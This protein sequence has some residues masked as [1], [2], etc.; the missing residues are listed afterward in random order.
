MYPVEQFIST[1]PDK[2]KSNLNNISKMS[3]K[4]AYYIEK[5]LTQSEK[6][7][8]GNSFCYLEAVEG[9]GVILLGLILE[10]FGFENFKS[11]ETGIID[12]K[13][14]RLVPSFSKKKRYALL[15]GK[16]QNMRNIINVFNHPDN[17]DGEYIQIIIASEVARDGINLHNVLRGYVLSP[18]WHESGMYQA[19][20]R[21]VR[22]TSHQDLKNRYLLEKENPNLNHKINVD[23]YRLAAVKPGENITKDKTFSFDLR[24]Y[25]EAEK[26]DIDNRKILRYM[27]QCAFDA[28]LN[29]NRN[30]RDTDVPFSKETDYSTKFMEIWKARGP[31]N[32]T[33]REGIALNQGPDK[34]DIV[35][36][37]Y[38]EFYSREVEDKIFQLL[39]YYIIDEGGMISIEEV[40]KRIKKEYPKYKTYQI[41][42]TIIKITQNNKFFVN[43][44]N[45]SIYYGKI[46]GDYLTAGK[47]SQ[48]YNK[49]IDTENFTV[50]IQ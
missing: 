49:T 1:N 23:V 19:L 47:D 9:S 30:V 31:P 32:N 41:Y 12:K 6:P 39:A 27:K 42:N 43:K 8:P 44:K 10:K 22:A 26:K 48:N 35:Y 7:R 29:Y 36:N 24:N 33:K 14:K 4:F 25:I 38:N 21:F 20:S 50:F 45:T 40:I 2:F 15:T 13:N 17:I 46:L 28:Y 18:G 16:T 3:C 11:N 34:K 5:E 37:T